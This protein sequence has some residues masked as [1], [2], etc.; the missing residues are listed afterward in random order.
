MTS[1]VPVHWLDRARALCTGRRRTILGIAGT[2][3]AGKSSFAEA[4]V[5]TL[6]ARA[7]LVPMDGFHLA[8][9]ELSRLDRA[10][11]KGAP[12]TF[13][14]P[15]YA[16][17]LARLRAAP[18]G[19]TIYAPQFRR[20][21]EEAVAGAIPV[22]PSV[23][24][25]VTEGNYLLLDNPPWDGV[26]PLL[27]AC[28]YVDIDAGTRIERLVARHRRHGRSETGARDWV[29]RSDEANARLIETT[30]RRADAVLRWPQDGE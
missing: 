15:G 28:W 17:L 6:G 21:I 8:G 22:A 13:D 19:E 3:G 1:G 10:D 23:D 27:D 5:E 12:D 25:V 18:P 29:M 4:L 20:E 24:L 9:S 14:V 7:V 16:A 2:P 30:R 11:R 26:R